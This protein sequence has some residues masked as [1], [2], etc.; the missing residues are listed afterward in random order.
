MPLTQ[1]SASGAFDL[2]QEVVLQA[3]LA[4]SVIDFTGLNINADRAY[5]LQYEVILGTIGPSLQSCQ[6]RV[7]TTVSVGGGSAFAICDFTCDNFS[8]P[9]VE[10]GETDLI[11]GTM[12]WRKLASNNIVQ[13][14]NDYTQYL[15]GQVAGSSLNQQGT[16]GFGSEDFNVAFLNVTSVGWQL[17]NTPPN[18]VLAGSYFRL[19]KGFG[20][21]I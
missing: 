1:P 8:R 16:P 6:P 13:L 10:Q 3:P 5:T 12:A 9:T 15:S 7:N 21:N 11:I 20:G 2:I 4:N 18:G 17:S 19:Y 14:F